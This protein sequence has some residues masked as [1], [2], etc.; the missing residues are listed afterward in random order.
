MKPTHLRIYF[1]FCVLVWIENHQTLEMITDYVDKE[2]GQ[3]YGRPLRGWSS[4]HWSPNSGPQAWPTA[5]V[6]KCVSWMKTTIR[7]LMHNDVLEEFHG[8]SFSND[9]I[10]PESWDSLLDTD[11]GDPTKEDCRTIKSVLEERVVNPFSA[12]IDNPS[13]G[14][15][16]SAILFGPPGMRIMSCK[17]R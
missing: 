5:Q 6:L 13:Y 3:C 10:Q 16:Y 17:I 14:A 11:I 7:Q 9:G 12:S 8:V 1:S 2:S 15:A 4:P